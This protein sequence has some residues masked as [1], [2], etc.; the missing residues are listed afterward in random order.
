MSMKDSPCPMGSYPGEWVPK[1]RELLIPGSVLDIGCNTGRFYKVFKGHKYTGVDVN[2]DVI[3][4]AKELNKGEWIC[5]DI[6]DFKWKDY[7]NIFSWVSL[8]HVENPPFEEIRKHC[9]N[10]IICECKE[11]DP[12]DYQFAHDWEKEFPG[13]KDYGSMVGVE[14]SAHLMN[15]RNK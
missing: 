6:N 5:S 3:A 8:Q 4:M 14:G 7:D 12:N 2:K 10:L 11:V 1:I 13:I 9:K 15:W